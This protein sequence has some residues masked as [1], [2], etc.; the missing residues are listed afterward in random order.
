MQRIGQG[1]SVIVVR[2]RGTID[3]C[4]AVRRRIVRRLKRGAPGFRNI[5]KRV[6]RIRLRP[7]RPAV[8]TG[9]SSQIVVHKRARLSVCAVERIGDVE[10]AENGRGLREPT[11]RKYKHLFRK[12]N[13]HFNNK[14]FVFLNQIT[15]DDLREFRN[16]WKMSPR[17]AGKHIECMKTFFKFAL[18]FEWIRTNPAKPMAMPKLEDSD[19]VPF[20][21]DQVETILTI[22]DLYDGNGKR[23]KALAE[24]MLWSGLRVM[25][26]Q[27]S[28]TRPLPKT[29]QAGRCDCERPR[30]ARTSIVQSPP[31]WL[32]ASCAFH[33]S[34]RSGPASRT[35][36]I[37]RRP[38]ARLSPDCSSKRGSRATSTS[39]GTRSRSACS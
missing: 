25:T 36:K 12:L 2:R 35:R 28:R 16:T 19:A 15:P 14:G 20:S 24:L 11:V 8:R 26:L 27:Q 34:I 38:D 29:K 32:R 17:T 37:A 18:D 39:S 33:T 6:V 1:V 22:C 13:D 3:Q 10:D 23:L 31:T 5:A 7:R 4:D 30:P 21:E 9:E